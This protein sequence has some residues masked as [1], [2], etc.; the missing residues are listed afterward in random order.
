MSD[1]VLAEVALR[2]AVRKDIKADVDT[3]SVT[4]EVARER[5]DQM[6]VVANE[7]IVGASVGLSSSAMADIRSTLTREGLG[8]KYLDKSL[9]NKAS[10]IEQRKKELE[11]SELD[12]RMKG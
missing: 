3:T 1:E 9:E 8:E 7:R 12:R 4:K 2:Q 6:A 10:E 5:E 11:M